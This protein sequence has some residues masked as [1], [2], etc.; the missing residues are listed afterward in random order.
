[1]NM[2]PESNRY[3]L[4]YP[5]FLSIIVKLQVPNLSILLVIWKKATVLDGPWSASRDSGSQH[6]KD[7]RMR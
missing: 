5:L 4:K 7:V 1:M 2:L 6:E 3:E